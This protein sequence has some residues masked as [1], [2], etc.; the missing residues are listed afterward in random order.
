TVVAADSAAAVTFVTMVASFVVCGRSVLTGRRLVPP[1]RQKA[2]DPRFS[3]AQNVRFDMALRRGV[4]VAAGEVAV[5]LYSS[6]RSTSGSQIG[7]RV[8]HPCLQSVLYDSLLYF[9]AEARVASGLG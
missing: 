6:C 2:T 3:M 9:S 5:S 7:N 1:R 8:A 4:A